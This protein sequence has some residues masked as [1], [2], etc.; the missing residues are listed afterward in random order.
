MFND[1]RCANKCTRTALK[2]TFNESW[3]RRDPQATDQERFDNYSSTTR[4]MY[5][6]LHTP[7][8][9]SVKI[10][11]VKLTYFKTTKDK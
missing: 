10:K 4:K 2:G 9:V 6:D 1:I 7:Y 11:I 5:K 8:S 3:S